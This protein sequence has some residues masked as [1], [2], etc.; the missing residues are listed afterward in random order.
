MGFKLADSVVGKPSVVKERL[1]LFY[2]RLKSGLHVVK[3]GKSSGNDSL[4]RMF[5]IQRDYYQKYRWTFM[6]KIK[7][8]RVVEENVFQ[9]EKEL[10]D[11]FA[12]YRYEAPIKFDGCSEMFVVHYDAALEV[13][14]Y[15][16]ENGLGSLEGMEFNPDAYVEEQDELPF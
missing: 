6:C 14:E 2:I 5:Q 10:H 9:Y 11:F 4:D 15:L 12:E 7:R 8:D 1:Y 16:L 13:F 3:I